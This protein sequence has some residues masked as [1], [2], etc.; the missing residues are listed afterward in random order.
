MKTKFD[1]RDSIFESIED[2]Y[3]EAKLIA[4]SSGIISGTEAAIDRLNSMNIEIIYIVSEGHKIEKGEVV[5]HIRS[6]P[7]L[8]AIA[9][10]FLVGKFSKASGIATAAYYAAELAKDKIKIVCG[11]LKKIP[12]ESKISFRKAIETGGISSR[13]CDTPFIYLDKN[14]IRMFGGIPQTLKAVEGLKDYKKVIQIHNTFDSVEEEVKQAVLYNADILMVD[15]GNDADIDKCF[16]VLK[17]LN[18]TNKV[19]AFAGNVKLDKIEY[20][21]EKGVNIL[22]IGKEIIDAKMLDMKF[23]IS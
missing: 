2:K 9:E 5:A 6:T 22:C 19:V 1:I 21:I 7:K 4:E 16:K 20:Y 10:D 18:V 23:D 17:E 12:E 8:L 11:S 15:T 3:Y 14:Y 13:I